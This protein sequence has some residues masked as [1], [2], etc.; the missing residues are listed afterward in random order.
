M[1]KGEAY[2]NWK[3]DR[4][5]SALGNKLHKLRIEQHK[6]KDAETTVER[7]RMYLLKEK[8]AAA[9]PVRT[10]RI[11]L[12]ELAS[13]IPGSR[14]I[15]I[16]PGGQRTYYEGLVK[17]VPES[18]KRAK[19]NEIQPKLNDEGE[20]IF[21]IWVDPIEIWDA[22]I[23]AFPRLSKDAKEWDDEYYSFLGSPEWYGDFL[24]SMTAS[25]GESVLERE[26]ENLT[27]LKVS[28]AAQ[29][30]LDRIREE[31]ANMEESLL[32]AIKTLK[33]LESATS[34]ALKTENISKDAV[35]VEADPIDLLKFL[36]ET[37]EPLDIIPDEEQLR[38]Y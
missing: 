7:R 1:K 28:E 27:K 13:L 36:S 19:V 15:Y 17:N 38:E 22:I 34:P 25:R 3:R 9:E 11:T 30:A 24:K 8:E 16:K 18:L 2:K 23:D 12:R 4:E 10:G 26:T 35:R 32:R 5:V 20:P 37:P 33:E 21:G 14:E 29:D 31:R 6:L